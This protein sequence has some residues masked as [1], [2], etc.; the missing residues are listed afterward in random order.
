MQGWSTVS[1]KIENSVLAKI[2]K[3]YKTLGFKVKETSLTFLDDNG[4]ECVQYESV[5]RR[6]EDIPDCIAEGFKAMCDDEAARAFE[7]E[8]ASHKKEIL[9]VYETVYWDYSTGYPLEE[10]VE[11][12][13][14]KAYIEKFRADYA[15][16]NGIKIEEVHDDKFQIYLDEAMWIRRDETFH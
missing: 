12:H 7:K 6:L 9:D 16:D 5:P 11:D 14:G 4:E 1:I 13:V 15:A 8:C 10:S 2:L 3:K